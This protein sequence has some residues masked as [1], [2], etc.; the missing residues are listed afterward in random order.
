MMKGSNNSKLQNDIH[1]LRI[2]DLPIRK[3]ITRRHGRRGLRGP[4]PART[5]RA[6][7][8]RY[9]PGPVPRG[10]FAASR[11]REFRELGF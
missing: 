1:D 11:R 2:Y 5:C 4:M 6:R 3:N 7:G 8:L 9:L 10:N